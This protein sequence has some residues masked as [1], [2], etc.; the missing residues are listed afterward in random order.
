MHIRVVDTA[1]TH[2]PPIATYPWPA[3]DD[4]RSSLWDLVLSNVVLAA[5]EAYL[6]ERMACRGLPVYGT[7]RGRDIGL[8]QESH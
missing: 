7:A 2:T 4:C 5:N 6:T 8:V 3:R 1:Y